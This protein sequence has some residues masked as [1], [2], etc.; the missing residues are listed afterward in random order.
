MSKKPST[1]LED[2]PSASS[3]ESETDDDD[4]VQQEEE[5]ITQQTIQQSSESDGSG[6]ESES[7]SEEE[8]TPNPTPLKTSQTQT[9]TQN[10]NSKQSESSSDSESESESESTET[11]KTKT[12]TITPT[13]SSSIYEFESDSAS[14]SASDFAIKPSKKISSFEP[15]EKKPTLKRCALASDVKDNK[16]KAKIIN[17]DTED[18]RKSAIKRVWSEED[19]IMLLKGFLDYQKDNGCSPLSDMDGFHRYLMDFVPGNA[20]KSQLYEKVRRLKKKFRV[21]SEKVGPNGEDP[22][23]VKPH[24]GQ[25]FKLMKKIWGVDG[26]ETVGNVG[27]SN[28]KSRVKQSTAKAPKVK[29]AK[30][31][32][33]P[34]MEVE[35]DDV[36]DDV[37]DDVVDDAKV[38]K[39]EDFETLYPYWYAGLKSEVLTSVSFPS[40]IVELV[41]ES[42]NAIGEEKAKEMDE[43]WKVIFETEA[44]LK[45]KRIA[46]M[47]DVM[48][49]V[50]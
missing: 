20:T 34:R 28:A 3:D 49:P 12:L 35:M 26:C 14:P 4:D 30:V 11:P 6:S 42:F 41:K 15:S 16:K 10:P 37:A 25:M 17:G 46:I 7:D 45:K 23:F 48:R 1:P 27:G 19:E 43:K 32:P 24:E 39:V 9:Q 36:A 22:T 21:N 29:V 50:L 33:K 13:K 40:G 31:K 47:C 38:G 18:G 8:Q 2:P 5:I 44:S